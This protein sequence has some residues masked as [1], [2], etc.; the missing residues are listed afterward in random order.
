[1]LPT[2]RELKDTAKREASALSAWKNVWI[3][4]KE[5]L[6]PSYMMAKWSSTWMPL[7]TLQS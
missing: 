7:S 6:L 3:K 1:L 4:N 2:Q 5:Q